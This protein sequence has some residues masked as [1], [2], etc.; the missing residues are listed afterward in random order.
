[1]CTARA[2]RKDGL[3]VSATCASCHGGHDVLPASDPKSDVA[4]RNIP[5]TCGACHVGILETYL[6]GVHGEAFTTGSADVPVCTDCHSEHGISA[7][8]SAAS[9]VSPK[10]VAETCARC[11]GDD[12]FVKSHGLKKGVRASWGSSYHGIASSLGAEGAA[13]CA[14]C[15]GF[16]DIFPSEDTRSP[17]HVANLDRTCGACH[18][19]ASAAFARVP[20]HS[21]IDAASNPVP[22]W[23]KTIYTWLVVAVIGAFVLFILL[24]LFGRLR[25]KL[26]WGPHETHHVDPLEWPDEDR[27]VAPGE[28]FLRMALHGRLQH[29][30]L[31][32]SFLLL[33]V[34]GVPVFLHDLGLMQSV[35]D[36]E[37]GYIL[38]SQ[39]HRI[40]AIGLIGLSLW[41]LAVLAL[42][43][44]ARRWAW[45]M[46]F[47]PRD[48][49]DFAQ[50]MN[51]NLGIGRWLERRAILRPLFARWPE[52]AGVERPCRGRYGL[53][54]KL[55]YGAVVWG[56]IVM[57]ATGFILWRPDWFL[58]WMPSWT[59][60]VSRVVH[61]FEATLAFLAIIIWHMYHVQMRPGLFL[62][63][64]VWFHGKMTREELRHHHPG[65]YLAILERR[66]VARAAEAAASGTPAAGRCPGPQACG[67]ARE[68]SAA[69][70]AH[71]N[72]K[73]GA[74]SW[75]LAGRRSR[76]DRRPCSSRRASG[77]S[78]ARAARLCRPMKTA[79]HFAL[80]LPLAACAT[81]PVE[82]ADSQFISLSKGTLSGIT[83]PGVHVAG[84][85]V[86][87]K[88]LWADHARVL[89]PAPA[90]PSVDFARHVVV[91]AAGGSRPSAGYAL[92]VQRVHPEDG[93]L[94]VEARE[95]APGT[96]T[97][98]A[99]VVTNPYEIVLVPRTKLE[100]V[101]RVLH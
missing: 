70:A 23:V 22:Y 99:Q 98:Q 24:D 47:R 94:V 80:L 92:S 51:F 31:V 10:L 18:S 85:A 67:A 43:P 36:L 37:G 58:D 5:T 57:I 7:T 12:E 3:I 88:A 86:S 61:G 76:T 52:L 41:H 54:E 68:R 95:S 34:T 56:N 60:D 91:F 75:S 15:H 66:R 39:M 101:L 21:T 100:L 13:N 69:C 17:I 87:W 2:L 49:L 89:M 71:L 83:T 48:V 26:G 8:D 14:S 19:N 30:V 11:H 73:G 27:L 78:P 20:V 9:H 28:K 53:V 82:P 74:R 44:K 40:G 33:V 81:A 50:E 6:G 29:A 4:R 1:V 25:L 55:E 77:T 45:S 16:H 72:Q 93:K 62:K 35:I 97:L 79:L 59:F 90:L 46:M 63:N 42:N 64:G 96:G 38:R 65:E 84:D 32:S